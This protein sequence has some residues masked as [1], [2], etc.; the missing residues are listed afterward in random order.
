M[1]T[2]YAYQQV[3]NPIQQGQSGESIYIPCF[4][5]VLSTTQTLD[6]LVISFPS[7]PF[8][9]QVAMGQVARGHLT[10]AGVQASALIQIKKIH[11]WRWFRKYVD[12]QNM[13]TFFCTKTGPF[14]WKHLV[15]YQLVVSDIPLRG[16]RWLNVLMRALIGFIEAYGPEFTHPNNQTFLFRSSCFLFGVTHQVSRTWGNLLPWRKFPPVV[17]SEI[18]NRDVSWMITWTKQITEFI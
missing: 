17:S 15:T 18:E 6:V 5:T 9:C 1:T 12:F 10:R 14:I 11:Q 4:F 16:L 13:S 2:P 7:H 3:G 8:L